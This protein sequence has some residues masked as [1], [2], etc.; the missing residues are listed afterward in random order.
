MP[1]FRPIEEKQTKRRKNFRKC[2]SRHQ[3]QA[4]IRHAVGKEQGQGKGSQKDANDL[5]RHGNGGVFHRMPH[6]GKIPVEDR[7]DR[8]R[9]KRRRQKTEGRNRTAVAQEDRS[10]KV[11]SEKKKDRG[12]R[13]ERKGI[14][15][16]LRQ[17]AAHFTRTLPPEGIRA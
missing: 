2:R 1:S 4:G 16:S 13:P 11:G 9:N 5:L 15:K 3:R 8:N 6:G 14:E 17:C 7:G 10:E 12:R